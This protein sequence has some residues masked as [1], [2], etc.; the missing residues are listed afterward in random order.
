MVSYH[1]PGSRVIFDCY[2]TGGAGVREEEESRL[3]GNSMHVCHHE[4]L[5]ILSD[6]SVRT[7]GSSCQ[8]YLHHYLKLGRA[9]KNKILTN[10]KIGIRHTINTYAHH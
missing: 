2:R 3:R 10:R 4:H 1:L 7:L 8:G 6:S 5:P 9:C